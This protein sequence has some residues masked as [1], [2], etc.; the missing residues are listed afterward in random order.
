MTFP[1]FRL[2]RGAGVGISQRWLPSS[3]FARGGW[4]GGWLGPSLSPVLAVAQVGAGDK[5]QP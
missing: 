3:H 5:G 4:G 2:S 1:T